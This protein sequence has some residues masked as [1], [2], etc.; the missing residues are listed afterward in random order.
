[1]IDKAEKYI[2]A[3]IDEEPRQ[4]NEIYRRTHLT[5]LYPRMCSGHLQGRILSMI[6]HM[7]A[8]RRILELGAFTG[9][10]TLCLA[11]GLVP[12]GRLVTVEIDDELEDE[13]LEEFAKAGRGDDIRLIIGDAMEVVPT[14]DETWDLV[15]IDANKRL[16]VDYFEMVV[17]KVRQGGYIIADNTLWGGKLFDEPLPTDPQS[18]GVMAFNDLVARDPR[19]STV[20]LPLRDGLTLMR[21]L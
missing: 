18:R 7:V 2:E 19:V 15:Y 10:S 17:D 3:H 8:P 6:S 14:L 16:Y 4:L 5:H 9:Y 21:R 20:M 11:E 12:G 1:M 13:L